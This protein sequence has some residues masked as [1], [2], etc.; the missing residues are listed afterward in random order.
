MKLIRNWNPCNLHHICII[1]HASRKRKRFYILYIITVNNFVYRYFYAYLRK[2][3][4]Q[5]LC[6]SVCLHNLSH[7]GLCT[8]VPAT[9]NDLSQPI[10]PRTRKTCHVQ[11]LLVLFCETVSKKYVN[12][13]A[14][15][16]IMFLGFGRGCGWGCGW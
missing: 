7:V 11:F 3:H 1:P 12:F 4:G 16:R 8:Y 13:P 14:C 9:L 10:R 6:F 5:N 2:D 15:I